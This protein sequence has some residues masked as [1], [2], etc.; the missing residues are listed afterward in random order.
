MSL[1]LTPCSSAPSSPF[2]L[3]M[4]SSRASSPLDL[5]VTGEP[6]D[7]ANEQE[8]RWTKHPLYF[9]ED[10]NIV[11]LVEETLYNIHRYFFARDSAFFRSILGAWDVQ[12]ADELNPYI[13]LDVTCAEF[14][15][16]LVILY[17]TDFFHPTL[18]NTRQWTLML[19]LSAKWGFESIKLLAI[20]K[21]AAS[22][23]PID[24]IVLGSQYGIDAWLP[25]AYEAA[26]LRVE[27]LTVKE[28]LTLG[29]EDTVRISAAREVYG[30]GKPRLE[31][32]SLSGDL[33]QIFGFGRPSEDGSAED[34]NRDE[35]AVRDMPES[36]GAQFQTEHLPEDT[37]ATLGSVVP[38]QDG[39][40]GDT[41]CR[42]ADMMDISEIAPLRLEVE[43][44]PSIQPCLAGEITQHGPINIQ[45]RDQDSEQV[46]PR[47]VAI[48]ND[49]AS[50][51]PMDFTLAGDSDSQ[52][53]QQP[54]QP[55]Q[56]RLKQKAMA[57]HQPLS[58]IVPAGG[59]GSQR[60]PRT[61]WAT[62]AQ[63]QQRKD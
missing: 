31:T 62:F 32:T 47:S 35:D 10:G 12:E 48:S 38:L 21:L 30:C 51:A 25:E 9:F 14:D 40:V 55:L 49:A 46:C 22:A 59:D 37:Y 34:T 57:A 17:P 2:V 43:P 33:N 27:P 52:E 56:E 50:Q 16:F 63:M 58:N 45:H 6:F 28:G 41:E 19:H 26:C 20:D 4:D 23:A 5:S 42:G 36:S 24:K 29:V 3:S 15:E 61:L 7:R 39:T 53:K 11:F 54:R 8:A 60:K 44:M 13:L 1:Q 18:K